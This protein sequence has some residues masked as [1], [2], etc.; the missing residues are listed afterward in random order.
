MNR[1]KQNGFTLIELI[2]V[3]VIL[4]ILAAVALPRFVNLQTDARIAK[5]NAARGAVQAA[6]ALVHGS[7]LARAGQGPQ[8]CPATGGN[9]TVN[10]LPAGNGSVCSETGA[11]PLTNLYPTA[12]AAGIVT[13]AGLTSATN[14][15]AQQLAAEGYQI[16]TVGGLLQIR[17]LGGTNATQCFFTYTP[18]N[19]A[20]G[21]AAVIGALTTPATVNGSTTGC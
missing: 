4:G 8:N 17:V 9:L 1:N 6:A 15:T 3:I 13:A 18:T 12:N 14:P 7:A 19:G 21:S 16:A 11:I 10:A 5:L 20:P 2:V